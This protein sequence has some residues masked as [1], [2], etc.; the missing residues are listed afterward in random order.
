[1]QNKYNLLLYK[2]YKAIKINLRENLKGNQQ[3]TSKRHRKD[4]KQS[5]K[6]R[7]TQQNTQLRNQKRGAT[8]TP[9]KKTPGAHEEQAVPAS[10]KI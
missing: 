7:Q 2:I 5:T 3:W 10:C 6:W 4:M 1:M 9:P 8:R